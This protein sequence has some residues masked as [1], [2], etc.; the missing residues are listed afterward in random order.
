MSVGIYFL[1]LTNLS[2]FTLAHLYPNF[3]ST[4]L[5]KYINLF[6]LTR[7]STRKF[8]PMPSLRGVNHT[9]SW[10]NRIY[11]PNNIEAWLAKV[12]KGHSVNTN[13]QRRTGFATRLIICWGSLY[14]LIVFLSLSQSNEHKG[15]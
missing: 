13:Y 7:A 10:G 11:Q 3:H 15:R 8:W 9:T 2:I 6:G 1:P 5:P 4:F 14:R 12:G